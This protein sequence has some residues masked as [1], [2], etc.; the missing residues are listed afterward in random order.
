MCECL[1]IFGWK[2]VSI[3]CCTLIVYP[4]FRPRLIE[5]LRSTENPITKN[6]VQMFADIWVKNCLQIKLPPYCISQVEASTHRKFKLTRRS[7]STKNVRE[8]LLTFG[9]KTVS[10]QCCPLMVCPR[11]RPRLIEKLISTQ[12]DH[13]QKMCVNVCSY[14]DENLSLF[15][16]APLLYIPG[17]G[18]DS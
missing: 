3:Q 10:I 14:L 8:C 13:W 4:K 17:L 11:L 5:R 6:C 2:T 1:Q 9:W 15:Y 7:P 18:V 12:K 16:I